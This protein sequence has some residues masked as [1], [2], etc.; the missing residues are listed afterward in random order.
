M[1]V[2]YRRGLIP[3]TA[4]ENAGK[5]QDYHSIF[6]I[7][8]MLIFCKRYD[9]I[10]ILDYNQNLFSLALIFCSFQLPTNIVNIYG[11]DKIKCERI[12]FQLT[13]FTHKMMLMVEEK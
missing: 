2:S 7:K 4:G 1:L 9:Q 10:K 5:D 13:S 6:R 8:L 11:D 3:S 12:D